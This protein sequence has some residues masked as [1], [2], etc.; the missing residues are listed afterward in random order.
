MKEKKKEKG[1]NRR[2]GRRTDKG[3]E[4]KK[5]RKG[6]RRPKEKYER[7]KEGKGRE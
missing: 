6:N 3:E 5:K 7:E 2:V 4:L 1:G